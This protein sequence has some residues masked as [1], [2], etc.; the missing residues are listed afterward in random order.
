MDKHIKATILAIFLFLISS[1]VLAEEIQNYET[2]IT[3]K[4]DATISVQ[5]KIIYDFGNITKTWDI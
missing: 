4:T 2:K 1:P 5:E 3:I